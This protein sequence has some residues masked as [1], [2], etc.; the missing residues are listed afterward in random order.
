MKVVMTIQS[1]VTELVRKE[2]EAYRLVDLGLLSSVEEGVSMLLPV[3]ETADLSVLDDF[4]RFRVWRKE[5]LLLF[6]R[7]LDYAGFIR[8]AGDSASFRCFLLSLKKRIIAT[9]RERCKEPTIDRELAVPGKTLAFKLSA[10]LDEELFQKERRVL[11]TVDTPVLLE[12]ICWDYC[13]RFFP[14]GMED[15]MIRLERDDSEFWNDLYLTIKKIAHTVTSGQSVSI[16]Y[17]K[18]VLQEVWADTSL[19]LHGKVVE[20]N[21][22]AFETPLHFRNYIA[23]MCLNKCREAIRKHNFP[24]IMLTVTGEMHSEAFLYEEEAKDDIGLQKGNLHDIDCEDEEEVRRG[25]TV[26]LWDKLEPWYSE[27]TRG[28]EEKTELIFLHYVEGL[29][30]EEIAA[31]KDTRVS[32]EGRSRLVGKLRQDVVRTRRLLK[33]RFVELLKGK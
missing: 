5:V 6:Y 33:L 27:L 20:K 14:V 29:S 21:T 1:A 7:Q 9:L 3:F 15:L 32:V 17:R 11:L 22:P 2:C 24:D 30:Y 13:R 28:I 23:R 31:M 8:E 18:D 19:L 16:Q 4:A 10:M 25:L 12:E 26:V